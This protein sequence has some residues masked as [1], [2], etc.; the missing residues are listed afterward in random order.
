[1]PANPFIGSIYLFAGNYAP[2]N[3]AFCDGQTISIA[4]NT[5][6]FSILGTT[7]GGDGRTTFKLPDFRGRAVIHKGHGPGLTPRSLGQHL[8][9]E[10]KTFSIA[11]MPGHNHQMP[12]SEDDPSSDEAEGHVLATQENNA[13]SSSADAF[14]GA[15]TSSKGGG[16][17]MNNVQSFL[18]VNYIIC[19][20]GTYPSRS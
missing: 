9:S 16:Q 2:R 4:Q 5:A 11:N 13:Y 12:V 6:L 17:A 1:M 14:Y 7:Y 8:G 18:G 20:V 19:L 15:T 10:T 3:Y